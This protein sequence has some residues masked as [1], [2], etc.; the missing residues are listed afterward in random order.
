MVETDNKLVY[1]VLGARNNGERRGEG[2]YRGG[3]A[4]FLPGCQGGLVQEALPEGERGLLEDHGK[5]ESL[6][7]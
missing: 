7:I 3:K 5:S 1:S 2:E 6:G 4:G